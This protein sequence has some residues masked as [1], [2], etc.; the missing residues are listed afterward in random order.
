MEAVQHT[1]N[2]SVC[3]V[4]VKHEAMLGPWKQMVRFDVGDGQLQTLGQREKL[5][6]GA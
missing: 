4:A 6:R 5:I 3:P 1:A 2:Y